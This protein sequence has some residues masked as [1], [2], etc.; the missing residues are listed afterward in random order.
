M[1][2]G[3]GKR[4]VLFYLWCCHSVTPVKCDVWHVRSLLVTRYL[5]FFV[6]VDA[7]FVWDQFT[8]GSGKTMLALFSAR[9]T[10]RY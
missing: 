2:A 3:R 7:K 1:D 10:R 8:S 6:K 9:A 5:E 4:G